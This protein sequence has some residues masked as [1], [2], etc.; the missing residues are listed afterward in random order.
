MR[1]GHILN[2]ARCATPLIVSAALLVSPV[3]SSAA[4]EEREW[5]FTVI[6]YVWIMGFDGKARIPG[7]P[8]IKMKSS[9]GEIFE[10]LDIGGMAA[11]EGK[12]GKVG[13]V[14]DFL[15]SRISDS[16]VVPPGIPAQ[17]RVTTFTSMLAAQ[18]ELH[19]DERVT[20]D[21]VLGIRYW[22]LEAKASTPVVPGVA[23]SK[24]T[25]WIDPQIGI[26]AK[27]SLAPRWHWHGSFLLAPKDTPSVDLAATL[28]YATGANSALH[29]GY[30]HLTVRRLGNASGAD[31]SFSG[32]LVGLA[33]RF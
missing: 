24:N 10:N 25:R 21:G 18:S 23:R 32:P 28:S 33:I 13:F 27:G 3:S 29:F 4:Q 6:P 22:A 31:A 1:L 7:L 8:E 30:R 5:S 2:R 15:Y 16:G 20:V 11:F 14:G 26:K 17:G 9:F 19:R 12:R